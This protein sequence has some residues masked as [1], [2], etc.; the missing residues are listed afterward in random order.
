MPTIF[1]IFGL[2]FFFYSDEHRPI[3]VH[4]VKGDDDAKIQ[5]EDEVKLV[6]NHGLKAKDL[7]RALELAEMYKEDII[8]TWNEYH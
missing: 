5:I 6:Y 8:N 1:E 2:R 7:K 4:V 3:H